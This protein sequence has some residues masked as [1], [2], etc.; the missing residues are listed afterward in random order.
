M[1][2]ICV[3]SGSNLGNNPEYKESAAGLGKLLAMEK[4]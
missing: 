1:N 4:I 2:R 3:Y